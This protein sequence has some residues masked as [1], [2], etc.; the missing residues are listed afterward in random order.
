MAGN[1][2]LST[3]RNIP[4]RICANWNSLISYSVASK[5]VLNG[6]LLGAG[7]D[8]GVIELPPLTISPRIDEYDVVPSL[9]VP[10]VN[11][12]LTTNQINHRK[13]GSSNCSP[14]LTACKV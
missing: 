10:R 5:I 3:T 6:L 4:L 13:M 12:Y 7:I 14:I 1:S 9:V 11:Q 2:I 8:D